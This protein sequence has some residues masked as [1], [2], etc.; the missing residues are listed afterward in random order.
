MLLKTV[1]M[2]SKLSNRFLITELAL[3]VL[4]RSNNLTL[5]HELF[6]L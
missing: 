6:N 1:A 2:V 5:C 3:T 4:I